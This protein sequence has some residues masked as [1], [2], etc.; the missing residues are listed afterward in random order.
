MEQIERGFSQKKYKWSTHRRA[1]GLG[2]TEL[3]NTL[4]NLKY[5]LI[6]L[7]QI[8][9]NAIKEYFSDMQ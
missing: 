4:H 5:K 2:K 7:N 9:M 6:A 8:T 3:W 1:C